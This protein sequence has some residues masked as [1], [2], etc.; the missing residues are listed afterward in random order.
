MRYFFS[1]AVP[2]FSRMLLVESGSRHI[3]EKLLGFFYDSYPDMQADLVT[4]F[5]GVPQNFRQDR[6]AV[7]RVTDYPDAESR[8]RFHEEL[9][10]NQYNVVAIICSAE[11]IMTK[12]KWWLAARLGGKVLVVNENS[13]YFWLDRGR[14]GIIW[15]FI[16][17]RAGLTGAGAISTIARLAL[18]PFTLLYLILYATTV[19][20]RRILRTL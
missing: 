2:P 13:D 4:C 18:F 3:Y 10:G 14:L 20:F 7:F 19:H 16:L 15:H 11:P 9:A 1:K 6:G 5:A 17:F 8:Q 12:W